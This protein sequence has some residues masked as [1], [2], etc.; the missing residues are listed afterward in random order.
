VPESDRIVHTYG[1]GVII[2]SASLRVGSRALACILA[3]RRNQPAWDTLC[4]WLP[5][6]FVDASLFVDGI[7]ST[8]R[9]T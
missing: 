7:K 2:A 8:W 5:R 3:M 6:R 4:G 1:V 9:S